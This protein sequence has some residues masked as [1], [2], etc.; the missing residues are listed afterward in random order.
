M[1]K[2][3]LIEQI[4]T[5]CL[6]F[7]LIAFDSCTGDQDP[8]D[9]PKYRTL[10]IS[11]N[12]GGY[13]RDSSGSAT[14]GGSYANGKD[15]TFTA[16]PYSG[17]RF[18]KWDGDI[19][20]TDNPITITVSADMTFNAIFVSNAVNTPPVA[21]DVA[22]TTPVNT[23]VNIQLGGSDPD[24]NPVTLTPG[25]PSHGT[26]SGQVP[27]L[28]YTPANGYVGPDSFTYKA[29]D[30]LTDSPAATV[31]ITV[32]TPASIGWA[33]SFGSSETD[34]VKSV[35]ADS[36]GNLF[37]TGSFS[38]VVDFD[39]GAAT[40]L[41]QSAGR[42]DIFLSKFASNGDLL[43]TLT[44]GGN[45]NDQGTSLAVDSNG[46]VFLVASFGGTIFFSAG[47]QTI[48]TLTSKGGTDVLIAKFSPQGA[49][50]WAKQIGGPG[51][52]AASAV[53]ADLAGNMTVGGAFNQSV[54]FNPG[55]AEEMITS[56]G[57]TDGFVT[58]LTAQG[59]YLWT[60]TYGSSDDDEVTGVC[61][62]STYNMLVAGNFRVSMKLDSLGGTSEVS[63]AGGSD[64]FLIKLQEDGTFIW[65]K[66][67]GGPGNDIVAT[68]K[69][70]EFGN[71]FL[72]GY[73]QQQVDFD[74]GSGTVNRSAS[75]D[76]DAFVT[77]INATGNYQWVYTITGSGQ[78]T[79]TNL[80]L[81]A[82]PT[83]YI[84]GTFSGATSF[85]PAD[86]ATK[87]SP[88]GAVDG[89]LAYITTAGTFNYVIPVGSPT[90]DVASAVT[91]VSSSWVVY[92]GGAFQQTADLDPRSSSEF[93]T[94]FG[95]YDSFLI[96]MTST[97][98]WD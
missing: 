44:I 50:L 37:V 73:F 22:V 87:V 57:K 61:F 17:Y 76:N 41:F 89:F 24:G 35:A 86:T 84:T 48:P 91:A 6:A 29:N 90:D 65:G 63:S 66:T 81:G 10:T 42:Q 43:W 62:D 55:T 59:D 88:V 68:M 49:F 33:K 26:L 39:P 28:T 1:K 34:Y 75:G 93:H 77:A 21:Y 14:S 56:A 8:G 78:E 79:V 72:G 60:M 47:T 45:Q 25:N 74:P 16:V 98:A 15:S 18:D 9:E 23:P 3:L 54:D 12:G 51:N 71:A 70:N 46:N 5:C 11:A 13:V 32:I 92:W 20:G 95:G 82:A 94:S 97:G 38:G 30:G 19:S 80:A 85:N 52:D 40:K 7:P 64:I 69:C 58:K 83:L 4:F 96:K 2:S 67:V 31:N 36:T 27:I 53:A